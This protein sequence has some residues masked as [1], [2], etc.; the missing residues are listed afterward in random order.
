[1]SE[2]ED[3]DNYPVIHS[4]EVPFVDRELS[5]DD[6]EDHLDEDRTV[7]N[8][9]TINR[10]R[11]SI[12][13]VEN[14]LPPLRPSSPTGRSN[15]IG[16]AFVANRGGMIE[17]PGSSGIDVDSFAARHQNI[18]YSGAPLLNRVSLISALGPNLE[19]SSMV[20]IEN[21]RP[22]ERTGVRRFEA[23][24]QVAP[25]QEPPQLFAPLQGPQHPQQGE[26][27]PQLVVPPQGPPQ[28]V[29][30][31]QEPP[32]L[33]APQSIN[34]NRFN[35][36]YMRQL[37]RVDEV[38]LARGA[39]AQIRS[40]QQNRTRLMDQI[41]AQHHLMEN[42]QRLM[43]H[44]QRLM[45]NQQRLMEDQHQGIESDARDVRNVLSLIQNLLNQ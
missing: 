8:A 42:Q 39:L 45:E 17:A 44:Q 34:D 22:S 15:S 10:I 4:E 6:E 18:N 41:N 9:P 33:V 32:Q 40:N 12:I 19:V 7:N 35:L 43:Q 2:Q 5:P 29:A 3:D 38:Q 28:Q 11:R 21:A 27:P 26:E 31:L 1:M 30:P 13:I 24:Q 14:N 36:Q 37:A 20:P 25:P 23:P 16:S